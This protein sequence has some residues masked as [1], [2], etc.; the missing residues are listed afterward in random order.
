M[1]AN[2]PSIIR[3]TRVLHGF[4]LVELLVVIAIIGILIALLLPAVQSAREAARRLQ[5]SNNLKQLGLGMHSYATTYQA[6][7]P[8]GNNAEEGRW[9]PGLM[10][11][12][13][14]Y[15]EQQALYSRL[16]VTGETDTIDD[17]TNKYTPVP[18]YTCPSWPY[19]VVY[20]DTGYSWLDGAIQTYMGT[21]GA[22][23]TVKPYTTLSS[24]NCPKNGMFGVNW[25]RR[26]A[27]VRDGLSNTLAIGEFVQIDQTGPYAD[28]PGNGRPWI[29]GSSNELGM[30]GSKVIVYA[31]NATVDRFPEGIPY[32]WLPLGSFHPG[33]MNGLMADGSVA[34]LAETI[35]LE[36]YRQL[37]TVNGGEVVSIP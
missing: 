14:P 23:P 9:K 5:C 24:G 35:E 32:N 26:V 33:G 22:Y 2:P 17:E 29:L 18:C 19:P 8:T 13:L 34:F 25:S 28:A 3:H 27:E 37:A 21:A 36:L 12:L 6:Y 1:R 10:T 7:F 30:Y 16:D 15:I 20:R 11:L 4:T 31:I